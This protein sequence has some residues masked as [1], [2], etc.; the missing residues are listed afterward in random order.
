[1]TRLPF[2]PTMVYLV[3]GVALGPVGWDV[4]YLD[5]RLHVALFQRCAEVAVVISLFT[6][7]MKLRLPW[8]DKRWAPPLVL[9]FASM[10]VTVGLIALVG[11]WVLHLPLGAAI[12]LGGI[13]APTDPVLASDVQMKHPG[14]HCDELR[15]RPDRRGRVQRR[16]GVSFRD[17]RPRSARTD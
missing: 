4:L 12:L 10:V 11:V 3:I 16:H 1:M 8:G 2:T 7:G 14:D 13:L 6:V 15:W 5:P 17:A 9:A